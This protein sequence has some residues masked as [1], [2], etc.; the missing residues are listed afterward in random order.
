MLFI[1]NSACNKCS[2]GIALLI[3]RRN[4]MIIYKFEITETLQKT[5]IIQAENEKEAYKLISDKYKDGEIV[6]N[7]DDFIDKEIILLD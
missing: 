4:N 2:R 5:I 7:A 1:I 6:L 3:E